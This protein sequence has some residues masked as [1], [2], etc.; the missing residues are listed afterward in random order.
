MTTAG[1]SRAPAQSHIH[2]VTRH[3]PYLSST[4]TTSRINTQ[5]PSSQPKEKWQTHVPAAPTYTT[6]RTAQVKSTALPPSP[7]RSHRDPSETPSFGLGAALGPPGGKWWD[8]ELPPPPAS[9]ES[10]LE[11]FRRSGE[12]DRDLLLAI[13]GAKKAEEER[14][15]ALVQ[16]RLAIL[17]ARLS[18]HS[19]G[20]IVASSH[21]SPPSCPSPAT[22]NPTQ[23]RPS[24]DSSCSTEH[25]TGPS[26]FAMPFSHS[27]N[28]HTPPL[29][30]QDDETRRYYHLPPPSS[31][32][33]RSPVDH[34]HRLAPVWRS[35]GETGMPT[36]RVEEASGRVP[37]GLEM[38]LD[39]GLGK[40][41]RHLEG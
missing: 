2:S 35:G 12:G 28:G 27:R 37:N 33:E 32:L 10:I 21:P 38:L 6:P 31:L 15:T 8:Q 14:L 36:P 25:G 41:R 16:S 1:P 4:S 7:P 20:A 39:A 5:S 13:L 23:S 30:V 19:T 18:I 17:Q 24:S 34:E 11:S 3:H 9:L 29:V 40:E 26:S 22:R